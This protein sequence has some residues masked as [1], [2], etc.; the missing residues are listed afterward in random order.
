MLTGAISMTIY[1][2]YIKTH[3]ITGLKYLGQTSKQDPISYY[4][5]GKDWLAHLKEYGFNIHTNIL[6]VCNSKKEL[7]HY[8]RYY[9]KLYRITTSVDNYG[10]R[11]W[12]NCIPE[13][14]GGSG[15][16]NK[17]RKRTEQQKAY[18]KQKTPIR[19]GQEHPGYDNTEYEWRHEKTGEIIKYT[20]QEFIKKF[21]A[22]P[23]NVC[24]HIN[25]SKRIVNGWQVING[26]NYRPQIK[27]DQSGSKS[28]RY[29][30]T[31]YCWKNSKTEEV[32]HLT[33]HD[34]INKYKLHSG[35]ICYVVAEKQNEHN[36]WSIV[37]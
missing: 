36:G 18:I 22:S 33:R 32:E 9:S 17:G 6:M 21:N 13:T 4:G 23:G 7:N 5:S 27:K 28:S 16:H 26:K 8:G 1:Y 30:H 2:L 3:K 20:R 37:R 25:G 29:D 35:R 10:N 15:E 34:L 31:V 19:Y 24:D 14:G 11:I 12:A